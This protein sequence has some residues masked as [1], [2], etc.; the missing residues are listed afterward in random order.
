VTTP[1]WLHAD[2]QG[3]TIAWS[4]ATGGSL[5]ALAYDPWGQPSAWS[6]PRYAYTGQLMLPE[7]NLYHYKARAY[8]PGLGRFLQPDPAGMASDTN[9]Y[10]YVGNNPISGSDSS[11]LFTGG[12]TIDLGG[13]C[14]LDEYFS[15]SVG[16]DDDGTTVVTG[17][18]TYFTSGSCGGGGGGGGGFGGDGGD[19]FSGFY[20]RGSKSTP[21]PTNAACQ[22]PHMNVDLSLGGTLFGLV[23]GGSAGVGV[24][25]SIPTSAFVGDF[26]GTQVYL[27]GSATGMGGLGLFAG[28][29][30]SLGY[31][32][33]RSSLSGGFS[34]SAV[35]VLAAG[36]GYGYGGEFQGQIGTL[37]GGL[38]DMSQGVGFSGSG[39][40]RGAVGGYIGAGVKG[41]GT[42]ATPAFLTGC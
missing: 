12:D 10:G 42:I 33:S 41:T 31:S 20:G 7:A 30:P 9:L 36:A 39:G 37:S 13:G 19:R 34:G 8:S 32:T 15:E 1:Q 4:N 18:N 6:G 40:P 38:G 16:T 28:A 29:G 3:S 26:R 17:Y 14:S 24:G 35:P 25:L 23:V 22:G 5:G 27:T 2:A 21:P 11:G